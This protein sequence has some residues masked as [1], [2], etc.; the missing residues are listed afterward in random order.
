MGVTRLILLGPFSTYKPIFY[1]SLH[2]TI[3]IVDAIELE[4]EV[5]LQTG[6]EPIFWARRARVLSYNAKSL[7]LH[8]LRDH[9]SSFPATVN[10][11][12]IAK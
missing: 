7:A 1:I 12:F 6:F 8:P 11:N 3:E 5:G 2:T 10:D 9:K 4:I